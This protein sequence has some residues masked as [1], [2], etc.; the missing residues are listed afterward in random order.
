MRTIGDA[1]SSTMKHDFRLCLSLVIPVW[2]RALFD[3]MMPSVFGWSL[4]GDSGE[5]ALHLAV[6]YGR[7]ESVRAL[8]DHGMPAAT[9]AIRKVNYCN[10]RL[11]RYIHIYTLYVNTCIPT[12]PHFSI[13]ISNKRPYTREIIWVIFTAWQLEALCSIYQACSIDPWNEDIADL[14]GRTPLSLAEKGLLL[15]VNNCGMQPCSRFMTELCHEE[16]Q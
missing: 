15:H 5:T 4:G 12:R 11:N 16:Y 6:R 13:C 14:D 1:G 3:S 8:L 2:A 9:W 10:R 7:F